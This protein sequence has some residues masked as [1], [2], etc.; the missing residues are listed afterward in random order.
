MSLR[1]RV[2]ISILGLFLILGAGCAKR[3]QICPAPQ[4]NPEHHYLMGMKLIE[5]SELK[6]AYAHFDRGVFCD[7]KY[8]PAHGGLALATALMV[9][10]EKGL[11]YKNRDVYKAYQRLDSAWKYAGDK[12][13]EFAYRLAS[14]RVY[15]ALKPEAW[16]KAV[17]KDYK[18]ALKLD[19]GEPFLYYEGVEA[20]HYFMGAAYFEAR[21]FSDARDSLSLLLGRKGEGKWNEGADRLWRKTDN[22]VRAIAGYTIGNVGKEISVMETVSRADMAALL[23][24]ELK[25]DKLFAGRIPVTSKLPVLKRGRIPA[26]VADSPL[27]EEI[28][29]VIKWGIRGLEPVYDNVEA[30][31]IFNPGAPVTRKEFAL[32]LEDVIIKLTGDESIAAAFFGH[33]R[34]PYPDVPPASPWY[35]AVMN[36]TTRFLMETEL[37]GEF[38]PDDPVDGAE[39]ILAIRLLRQKMIIY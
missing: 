10:E 6:D 8:G 7:K 17:V 9:V 18:K 35:N 15:T 29:T 14:M 36:V 28:L 33:S 34:S 25:I 27:R 11:D 26:D 24:D 1:V 2:L 32:T 30:R 37:S 13:Q 23:V 39:A 20:A 12:E 16:L 22:V 38:R 19:L 21:E 31:Y 3:V 4:D 5:R